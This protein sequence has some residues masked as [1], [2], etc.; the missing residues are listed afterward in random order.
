MPSANMST[1]KLYSNPINNS[2]LLYHRVT[3]LAVNF[4]CLYSGLFACLANPKSAIFTNPFLDTS[5]LADFMSRCIIP[6]SCKYFNPCN[7]CFTKDL[8]I[9]SVNLKFDCSNPVKS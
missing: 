8:I 2:G 3:T 7:I 9:G 4:F 1:P 5:M 6:K